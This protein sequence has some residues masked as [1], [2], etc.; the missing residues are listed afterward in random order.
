[1]ATL[2]GVE[3][4]VKALDE[5]VGAVEN[6]NDSSQAA[7]GTILAALRPANRTNAE[8]DRRLD[9]FETDLGKAKGDL[10]ES[11]G[12]EQVDADTIKKVADSVDALMKTVDKIESMRSG[13]AARVTAIE[14]GAAVGLKGKLPVIS[15]SDR[16]LGIWSMFGQR[17]LDDWYR[18]ASSYDS[19]PLNFQPVDI[20]WKGETLVAY[21]VY[22]A[23]R[24]INYVGKIVTYNWVR[25]TTH[26]R[27]PF[28]FG[29][30]V[31]RV[32]KKPELIR[33]HKA[34]Q[35]FAYNSNQAPSARVTGVPLNIT[36]VEPFTD[37][38]G[39]KLF[40]GRATGVL[41][42]IRP[43]P[44]TVTACGFVTSVDTK[45]AEVELPDWV[46]VRPMPA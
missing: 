45:G 42:D 40:I 17:I 14:H 10:E 21:K 3:A 6:P 11:G 19:L 30:E 27:K 2:E 7:A 35:L 39:N 18:T 9:G 4:Q 8:Q 41:R 32:G 13:F 16:R 37:Q 46:A 29:L 38:D 34:I 24:D 23:Q 5:K 15:E 36:E 1:M 12:G 22:R 44:N 43:S 25:P 31:F 26:R 33:A 28:A 20:V